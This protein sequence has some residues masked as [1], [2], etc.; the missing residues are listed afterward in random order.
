MANVLSISRYLRCRAKGILAQLP[1]CFPNYLTARLRRSFNV[2][3]QGD[4]FLG[5]VVSVVFF[6]REAREE[7]EG[8]GKNCLFAGKA[9]R[10]QPLKRFLERAKTRGV[11][12]HAR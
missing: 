1:R 9:A 8:E 4:T 12:A 10:L 11:G 5:F 7:R 2:H 3:L 6:N